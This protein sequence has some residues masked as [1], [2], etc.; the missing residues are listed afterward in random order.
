MRRPGWLHRAAPVARRSGWL[1]RATPLVVAIVCGACST[2]AS[3]PAR[4]V[5]R[6]VV[7][8]TSTVVV[9]AEGQLEPRSIGSYSL[10][11]YG[12]ANPRFPTDDFVTGL[13]RS[14]DGTV[15]DL[16]FSDVDG[17]GTSD[18]VVIMRSAGTGGYRSADAFRLQGTTLSL[19]ESIKGLPKDGDPVQALRAKL[20]AHAAPQADQRRP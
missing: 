18:I 5:V 15:E 3:G 7:P 16:I 2:A 1:H 10:T 9:V 17:D 12:G 14:R 20:G 4:G 6:G 19:V 11:I 13:V 8:G